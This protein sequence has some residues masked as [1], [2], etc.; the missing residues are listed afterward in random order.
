MED[1]G[2]H[3]AVRAFDRSHITPALV[4]LLRQPFV[5]HELAYR[6]D[7]ALADEGRQQAGLREVGDVGLVAGV[8]ADAD[9]AFKLFTADVL[10][11]DARRLF[12]GHDGLLELHGVGVGERAV[13]HDDRAAVSA[14]HGLFERAAGHDREGA[15]FGRSLGRLTGVGRR[16]S[17]LGHGLLGRLL[18]RRFG[19]GRLLRAAATGH[20]GQSEDEQET[21]NSKSSELRHC[22]LFLPEK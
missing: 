18:H 20:K 13:D 22:V 15:G 16:C 14:G 6:D 8:D 11:V 1:A 19:R 4:V 21:Q 5:R 2:F 7:L 12:E 10:H 9:G 17:C 3:R